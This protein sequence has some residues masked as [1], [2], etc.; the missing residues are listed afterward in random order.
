MRCG[1]IGEAVQRRQGPQTPAPL[2]FGRRSERSPR[3]K[4]TSLLLG[5]VPSSPTPTGRLASNRTGGPPRNGA[6]DVRRSLRSLGVPD[7]ER[8]IGE[9]L[10]DPRVKVSTKKKNPELVLGV[11]LSSNPARTEYKRRKDVAEAGAA[12]A[13]EGG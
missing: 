13:P 9:L 1:A 11:L 4:D 10:S 12:E 3:E 5:G 7:L 2:G 6:S 8:P